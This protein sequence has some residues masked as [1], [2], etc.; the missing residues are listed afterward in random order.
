M[1]IHPCVFVE[2]DQGFSLLDEA[3]GAKELHIRLG[4]AANI[5]VP[6]SW[7]Q[8]A[9]MASSQYHSNRVGER[10][11]INWSNPCLVLDG[12]VGTGSCIYMK[13]NR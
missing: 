5:L 13:Y 9:A 2:D 12:C 6:S 1:G 7:C 4:A 10:G 11:L 3:S 8:E